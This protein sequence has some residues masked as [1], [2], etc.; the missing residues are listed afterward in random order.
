VRIEPQPDPDVER[1]GEGRRTRSVRSSEPPNLEACAC[2]DSYRKRLYLWEVTT[3]DMS[4]SKKVMMILESLSNK[5]SLNH[6]ISRGEVL[7]DCRKSHRVRDIVVKFGTAVWMF[8]RAEINDEDRRNLI[9][10]KLDQ[11][12]EDTLYDRMEAQIREVL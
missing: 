11:E 1:H 12:K 5:V 2:Y 4:P 8:R 7:E 6:T 9:I 10:S 3:T